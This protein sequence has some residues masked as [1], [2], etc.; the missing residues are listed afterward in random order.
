M[1]LLVYVE[2]I[3]FPIKRKVGEFG[4]MLSTLSLPEAS[5]EVELSRQLLFAVQYSRY[6]HIA[7]VM[8]CR[9][10]FWLL[11]NYHRYIMFVLFKV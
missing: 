9:I 5:Y 1:Y 4:L 2:L 10:T 8:F 11:V 6:F 3:M 7:M